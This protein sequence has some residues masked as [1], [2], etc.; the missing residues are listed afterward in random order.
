MMTCQNCGK[1]SHQIHGW[2]ENGVYQE[3]CANEDCGGL[4]SVDAGVPDVFWNGRPYYSQA[5]DCE[6][7]SRSQKARIMKEKNVRE[8]GNEKLS[9]KNWTEGSR[10][11]RKRM[12]DKIDRP[13]IR[14]TYKKFMQTRR[15][16]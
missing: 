15:K 10:D 12:F 7:T 8:L 3:V 13:M 16:P 11:Y 2:I 14:E 4:H 9:G 6:F 5:L 1:E